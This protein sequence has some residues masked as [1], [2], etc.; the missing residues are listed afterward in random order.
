MQEN[1]SH[2]EKITIAETASKKLSLESAEKQN[3]IEIAKRNNE[4]V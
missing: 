4:K 2:L 1:N 3:E